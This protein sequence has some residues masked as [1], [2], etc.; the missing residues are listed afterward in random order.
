LLLLACAHAGTPDDGLDLRLAR[1]HAHYDPFVRK[2]LGCPP[3][4]R[5]VAQCDPKLG[6]VDY[7]EFASACREAIKLFALPVEASSCGR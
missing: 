7:R 1:F 6:A 4:A 2:Y 5:E 3:G